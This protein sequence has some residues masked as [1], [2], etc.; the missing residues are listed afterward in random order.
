MVRQELT[1][2]YSTAVLGPT[3]AV[4]PVG[5]AYQITRDQRKE[6]WMFM[7]SADLRLLCVGAID[8]I[9]RTCACGGDAPDIA[10]QQRSVA[11]FRQKTAV[12]MSGWVCGTSL[13]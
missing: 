13:H 2:I 4:P 10:T 11:S 9:A 5:G 1:E 8:G 12:A 6:V 7:R 3:P